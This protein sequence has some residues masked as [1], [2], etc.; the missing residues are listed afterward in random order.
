VR[1]V[2]ALT[3]IALLAAACGGGSGGLETAK[4]T[5]V[6]GDGA[7]T[8]LAVELARTVEERSRGLMF[9]EELGE[10]RGMLFVFAEDSEGSFWMKDTSI[11]LSIAFIEGDGT[12]LDVQDMEPLTEERH[13]P[14][15]PY[16]YALE[17]NQGWFQ[18]HDRGAG[19]V[20]EIPSFPK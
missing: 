16:R 8:E 19:D 9:R 18:R 15:G 17:V 10:D 1:L 7:R 20:V 5:L 2:C 3:F 13:K 14:P 12:I 6:G 4:I 11:P